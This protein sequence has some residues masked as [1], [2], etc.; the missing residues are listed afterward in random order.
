[1]GVAYIRHYYLFHI[2]CL[3]HQNKPGNTELRKVKGHR[4]LSY[5][6]REVNHKSQIALL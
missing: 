2:Q 3:K 6:R 1:M 4:V 5:L